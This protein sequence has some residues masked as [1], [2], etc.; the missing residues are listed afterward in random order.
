MKIKDKEKPC[1]P[2]EKDIVLQIE[3]NIDDM[4]PKLYPKVIAKLMKAGALDAYVIPILMK[5]NRQGFH[6]VVLC[7]PEMREKILD[8]VF[9]QTTT[10]GVRTHLVPREKLKRKFKKIETKYGRVRVKLGIL[11]KKVK[12]IAP[13]YEDYK[14]LAGKHHIP[15]QKVYKEIWKKIITPPGE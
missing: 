14:K 9:T 6:L 3:T 15:I 8:V 2:T 10:F 13:E 12:T 11:D 1:R 5:K 7:H 4:D